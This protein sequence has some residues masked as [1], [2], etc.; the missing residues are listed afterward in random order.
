M[1]FR[2]V[3]VS[4]WIVPEAF[5]ATARLICI[6]GTRMPRR[7][8]TH[9]KIKVAITIVMLVVPVG[10]YCKD[11]SS[12]WLVRCRTQTGARRLQGH[13]APQVNK[14]KPVKWDP[15]PDRRALRSLGGKDSQLLTAFPLAEGFEDSC[16]CAERCAALTKQRGHLSES[17]PKSLVPLFVE[18]RDEF[19]CQLLS[20]EIVLH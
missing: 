16:G 18:E 19:T 12:S 10:L 2:V 15:S 9:A 17:L 8:I 5:F 3:G 1:T 14:T 4:S 6:G 20:I 7:Q 13:S 11:G